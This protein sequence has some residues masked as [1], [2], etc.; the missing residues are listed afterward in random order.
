MALYNLYNSYIDKMIEKETTSKEIDFILYI[1]QYQDMSGKV[2]SVY[3]KDVCNVIKISHTK[4]Y[5]ILE[6][7]TEK[8]LI[9]YKKINRADVSVQFVDNDFRS[10][11]FKKGSK[12]YLKV[13]SI[14][15]SDE[16]FCKMKAGSKLLFLYMQRFKQGKHMLVHN[17]YEE[18]SKLFHCVEKS[19]QKY[20]REL[21]ENGFLY[22]SKKRNKAYNYEMTMKISYELHYD[23]DELPFENDMYI[24]N[25]GELI[26]RNFARYVP[27]IENDGELVLHQIAKLANTQRAK[28]YENFVLLMVDAVSRSISQQK[29]EKK[30]KPI[31][32]AALVNTHLTAILNEEAKERL[33]FA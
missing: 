24:A 28:K 12:G 30:K 11:S 23:R 4:F 9:T 25:V 5:D 33:Q 19:L 10:N 3:Y 8:G 13:A 20:L 1:A 31:L 2:E 6:D 16:T 22:I 29:Y 26:R 7:L 32:N 17:F 18:F 15:F 21:K 27:E 14:K